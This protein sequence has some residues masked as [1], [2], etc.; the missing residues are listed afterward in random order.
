MSGVLG[1]LDTLLLCSDGLSGEVTDDRI[2]AILSET[3]DAQTRVDPLIAAA[4]KAGGKDN[5]TVIVLTPR[6]P[7]I[8]G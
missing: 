5:I 7:K 1:E 4:L 6:Q 8:S 2:A 3:T